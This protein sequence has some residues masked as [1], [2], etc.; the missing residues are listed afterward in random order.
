MGDDDY[1]YWWSWNKETKTLVLKQDI[2]PRV[3]KETEFFFSNQYPVEP[4]PS[5]LLER[6]RMV[7]KNLEI[8]NAVSLMGISKIF[9]KLHSIKICCAYSTIYKGYTNFPI[10]VNV[11]YCY[12]EEEVIDEILKE[13]QHMEEFV[14][15]NRVK[16]R[17]AVAAELCLRGHGIPKDVAKIISKM[18]AY[19]DSDYWSK[20]KG[21]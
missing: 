13:Q 8:F 15:L 17:C 6:Y 7:V 18:L 12:T 21:Q 2:W 19:M 10:L 3:T 14:E 20:Q 4:T 1:Q 11:E 9:P 16:I 5:Q